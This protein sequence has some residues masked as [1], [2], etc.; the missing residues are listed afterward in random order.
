MA[1]ARRGFN[2]NTCNAPLGLDDTKNKCAACRAPK[3]A[4]A[5]KAIN[6]D[7]REARFGKVL[8]VEPVTDPLS[9]RDVVQ[10]TGG[11]EAIVNGLGEPVN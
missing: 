6:K 5:R 11:G 4:A 7:Y 8:S 3:V 2:C 9:T 10:L 1:K